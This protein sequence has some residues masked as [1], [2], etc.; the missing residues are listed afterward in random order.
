M[1]VKN[2]VPLFC[3]FAVNPLFFLTIEICVMCAVIYNIFWL[4]GKWWLC[5]VIG[6][7]EWG[8]EVQMWGCHILCNGR[9][10]EYFLTTTLTL[11]L[12]LSN[13]HDTKRVPKRPLWR[14]FGKKIRNWTIV[15]TRSKL[16]V[17]CCQDDSQNLFLKYHV[18]FFKAILIYCSSEFKKTE[19]FRSMLMH[20]HVADAKISPKKI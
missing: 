7:W 11:I 8:M 6:W 2:L 14:E 20:F 15:C 3:K 13:L 18:H 4:I 17:M 1:Y 9:F 19:F 10:L 12:T 16:L 5:A